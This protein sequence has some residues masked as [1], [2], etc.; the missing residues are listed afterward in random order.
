MREYSKHIKRLIREHATRLYEIELGQALGKL[1]QHFVA[2]HSGHIS[3]FELSDHIHTFHQSPA[4]ELGSRYNARID[5]TL[6]AHAIVTDLL[7]RETIPAE[8]L[9]ALQPIMAFYEYE[10]E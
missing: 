2:W 4:R 9:E 3:A 10:Q 5:D 7:P 8:L 1:E 6:V